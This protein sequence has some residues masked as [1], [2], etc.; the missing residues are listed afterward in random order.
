M[1]QVWPALLAAFPLGQWIADNRRTYA[2]GD[3][4]ADRVAQLEKL[5]VVWSHFDVAWEEG[6]AAARGWAAECGHLLAPL[7]AVF[8]SYRVGTGR[9][10]RGP[11]LARR[12]RSSS[13]EPRACW[14]VRRPG[15]LSEV[16]CEQMEDIDP[17][18]CPAWPVEWQRAFHL[19][20]LHL[21]AGRPLPTSPRD[22]VHQGED[23]GPVGLARSG[24]AGDKLTTVQQWRCEQVLGIEPADEVEKPKSRRTQADKWA[25]RRRSRMPSRPARARARRP[26]RVY[27][28]ET[29]SWLP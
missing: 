19:V 29:P 23:L 27:G 1:S 7:D 12:P 9:R 22:V 26:P 24:T 18:W 13:G 28:S 3:M 8:Q 15:A 21:D 2:R 20:R 5:G 11:P 17:C 4:D 25:M 14:W 6:L 10:T 16:R